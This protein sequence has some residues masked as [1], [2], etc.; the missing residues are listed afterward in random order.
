MRFLKFGIL[1]AVIVA[2]IVLF[3]F[4]AAGDYKARWNEA[5]QNLRAHR[6]GWLAPVLFALLMAALMAV[7]APR[8]AFCA[9][10]GA[11]FG[12]F[13][14]IL[15]A[16]IGALIGSYALFLFV[17]RIGREKAMQ[18]WP[19]LTRYSEALTDGGIIT[20]LMGRQLPINGFF[21]TVALALTRLTHGQFLIGTALGLIPAAIP[22]TLMG[23]GVGQRM[24]L[25]QSISYVLV[26]VCWLLLAG[27]VFSKLRRRAGRNAD[28]SR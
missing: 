9:A 21:I 6:L 22:A 10:A 12:F 25:A 20:V 4:T 3:H 24:S 13:W 8:L 5:I 18:R 1:I 27:L 7:G 28:S 17:R 11:T 26:A 19:S 14:G 15:W 2:I 23:A 16:E